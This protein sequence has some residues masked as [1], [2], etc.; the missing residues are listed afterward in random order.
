V[1]PWGWRTP[2]W[3]RATPNCSPRRW[4]DWGEG[5]ASPTVFFLLLI[6][7]SLTCGF[8]HF[9]LILNIVLVKTTIQ[10]VFD[11]ICIVFESWGT[12]Y[13]W[14]CGLEMNFRFD[15]KFEGPEVNSFLLECGWSFASWKWAERTVFQ[16]TLNCSL[17]VNHFAW[18]FIGS[19]CNRSGPDPEMGGGMDRVIRVFAPCLTIEHCLFFLIHP[20]STHSPIGA[21]LV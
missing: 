9:F 2:P 5:D 19:R 6:G 18:C 15:D 13:I 16:L 12:R 10:T 20:T 4:G 1:I 8:H 17:L 11:F 3:S 21:F 7:P 14:Y